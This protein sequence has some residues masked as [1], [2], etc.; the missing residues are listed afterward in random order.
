MPM[1]SL[2]SSMALVSASL[3]DI[4]KIDSLPKEYRYHANVLKDHIADIE[5]SGLFIDIDQFFSMV[6]AFT[7][8]RRLK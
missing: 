4:G 3:N 8:N 7:R 5:K 6:D 1:R 2:S